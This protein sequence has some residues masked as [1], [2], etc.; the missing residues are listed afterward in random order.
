LMV[1]S[2]FSQIPT[3]RSI[4]GNIG[5]PVGPGSKVGVEVSVGVSVGGIGVFVGK[6]VGVAVGLALCVAASLVLTVALAVSIISAS[7]IV[8]VARELVQE[9]SI[10]PASNKGTYALPKVF[11]LP[12]PL[13]VYQ[14]TFNASCLFQRLIFDSRDCDVSWAAGLTASPLLSTLLDSSFPNPSRAGAI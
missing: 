13:M 12:L 9:A 2:T 6:G 8:G 14:K 3:K 5:V 1:E 10:A 7:L 4:G 11:I